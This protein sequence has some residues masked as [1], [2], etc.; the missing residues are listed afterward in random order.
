MILHSNPMSFLKSL[1][2][3]P[4]CCLLATACSAEEEPASTQEATVPATFT[5]MV[6]NVEN[7][8]D[9]DEIAIYDDYNPASGKN[10][11][12][13]SP[14]KLLTKIQHV[15]RNVGQLNNGAGPMVVMFQ[16][17]EQD[18]TPGE[19]PFDYTVFLE[20]YKDTTVEEMLTTGFNDKIA[21]LSADALVLKYFEDNGLP[22]YEV[23]V[24]M[25]EPGVDEDKAHNNVIFS[26]FPVVDMQAIPTQNARPIQVATLD[27]QGNPLVL[28][29]NHWKSGAS[30][31]RTE[32][33]RVANATDVRAALDAILAQNP[34]ADVIIAGDLNTYYNAAEYFPTQGWDR[35]EYAIAVLGSQ[36][37]ELAIRDVNGPVLYN[38]WFELPKEERRSELYQGS[39]GTLMQML[40]TRGLYDNSGIQYQD[41]SFRR[42]EIPGETVDTTWGAPREWLFTGTKGAGYSDHLPVAADFVV[43]GAGE[44]G[45]Y[46][47]LENPSMEA[48]AP[49]WVPSIDYS[50]LDL[51]Q[52]P[53]AS[54][55]IG[56]NDDT[57][58]THFGE[59]YCVEAKVVDYKPLTIRLGDRDMEVYSYD[60]EAREQLKKV[61]KGRTLKFYGQLGEYN[62]KPQFVVH[63]ASWIQ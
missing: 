33:H 63:D 37:N 51:A 7:L 50:A 45:N 31:S 2:L 52:Q 27:V 34:Y 41:G 59:V 20:K 25:S 53:S 15:A 44:P 16:E 54:T 30:S 28:I 12:P 5:V 48:A 10:P 38:L 17:F 23:S 14:A 24:A 57:L 40:I 13:Y 39:W 22:G 4:L 6:Y 26:R 62:G 49:A 11:S 47:K 58:V 43:I 19:L 9:V 55:L 42:L 60:P 36:G 32:N 46:I 3:L 1:L 29:N 8:F 35:D 18:R 56:M 61:K 21:D